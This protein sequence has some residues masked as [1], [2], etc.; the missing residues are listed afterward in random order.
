MAATP[1]GARQ[2]PSLAS[3]RPATPASPVS[4]QARRES[5]PNSTEPSS[6]EPSWS[7]R[8]SADK[9]ER[10]A[11]P[12]KG[13]DGDAETTNMAEVYRTQELIAAAQHRL[14]KVAEVNKLLHRTWVEKKQ[15]AEELRQ[16]NDV[17]AAKIRHRQVEEPARLACNRELEQKI[18]IAKAQ[19]QAQSVDLNG[20]IMEREEQ[21]NEMTDAIAELKTQNTH[22]RRIIRD[23]DSMLADEQKRIRELTRHVEIMEGEDRFHDG[24]GLEALGG[25]SSGA[26]E[27][28]DGLDMDRSMALGSQCLSPGGRQEPAEGEPS[29]FPA[30]RQSIAAKRCSLNKLWQLP[31]LSLDVL[32]PGAAAPSTHHKE[33]RRIV[34]PMR[35]KA[36]LANMAFDSDARATAG[37]LRDYLPHTFPH[38]QEGEE[39]R[40]PPPPA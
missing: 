31:G 39:Q 16:K 6:P 18:R 4:H 9:A 19:Q 27:D 15:R 29:P 3:V 34:K 32:L 13:R 8:A 38:S 22:N 20:W 14:R 1:A 11:S 5:R 33:L 12:S 26:S 37:P 36:D 7:R 10:S 30:E 35:S 17:L 28:G 24:F 23:Q 25:L 2:R 21:I 40:D